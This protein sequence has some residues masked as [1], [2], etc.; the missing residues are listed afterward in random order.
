MQGQI[1]CLDSTTDSIVLVEDDAE[2]NCSSTFRIVKNSFIKTAE[3]LDNKKKSSNPVIFGNSSSSIPRP[4][5]FEEIKLREKDSLKRQT[6]EKEQQRRQIF[7]DSQVLKISSGSK[8]TD[9]IGKSVYLKLCKVLPLEEIQVV[10]ADEIR[11][12][13]KIRI[14]RPFTVNELKSD[15]RGDADSNSLDFI[16]SIVEDVNSR[17]G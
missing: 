5:N 7:I 8:G 10:S 17:G 13:G 4:V 6:R 1:Y 11:I 3:V 9:E 14:S 12:F 2:N 15:D 16:T